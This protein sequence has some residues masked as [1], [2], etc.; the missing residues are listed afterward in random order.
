MSLKVVFN[1]YSNPRSFKDLEALANYAEQQSEKYKTEGIQELQGLGNLWL[2]LVRVV[3]AEGA[4]ENILNQ[5]LEKQPVLPF[6]SALRRKA[7]V[8]IRDRRLDGAV[9][10]FNRV[11]S[12]DKLH[13]SNTTVLQ[14]AMVVEL[15][16]AAST[17]DVLQKPNTRTW[18][19]EIIGDYEAKLNDALERMSKNSEDQKKLF[20]ERF[21]EMNEKVESFDAEAKQSCMKFAEES[22]TLKSNFATGSEEILSRHKE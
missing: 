11:L 4:S 1:R 18:L 9:D 6:Q 3:Q 17:E 14:H 22:D 12:S 21:H 10:M 13:P 15:I 5:F 8:M 20:D 19:N 7:E 2:N 16:A